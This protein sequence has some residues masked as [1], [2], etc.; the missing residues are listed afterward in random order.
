M[1]EL[2]MAYAMEPIL[3][4]HTHTHTHNENALGNRQ[5]KAPPKYKDKDIILVF[6]SVRS[7][8]RYEGNIWNKI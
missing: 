7:L 1:I 8:K 5:S 4:E 6:W 2:R 3:F